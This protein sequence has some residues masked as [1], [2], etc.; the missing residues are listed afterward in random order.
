M[1]VGDARLQHV[2]QRVALVLNCQHNHLGQVLG[3]AAEAARDEAG[4]HRHA[5]RD[6]VDRHLDAALRRGAAQ[7]AVFAGRRI[8]PLGQ[9]VDLV[10]LHDVGDVGVA[11]HRV[12]EVVAADAVAVAIA[13]YGDDLQVVVRQLDASRHRQGATVDAVVG[14]DPQVVGQLRAAADATDHQR[15]VR[16]EAQPDQGLLQRGKDAE[17][18]A[19]GTPGAFLRRLVHLDV[20]LV[21]HHDALAGGGTNECISH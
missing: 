3:V 5:Q 16:R 20:N 4:A 7:V 11:A 9:A 19:A 14:V 21:Y 6:G 12:N 13:G 10:V 17:V 8:L 18:A 1:V 2:N 15:L